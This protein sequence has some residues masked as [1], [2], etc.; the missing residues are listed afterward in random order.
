MPGIKLIIFSLFYWLYIGTGKTAIV[1]EVS[2]KLQ[3]TLLKV[4]TSQLF[5][6]YEK[7]TV[8]QEV[9]L[10]YIFSRYTGDSEKMIDK[11]FEAA[12]ELSLNRPV[13]V[14]IDEIDSIC[15]SRRDDGKDGVTSR[16]VTNLLMTKI[17]G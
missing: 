14:F 10:I 11:Y 4:E 7:Q 17:S 13:I 1:E 9:L 2:E 15:L 5:S 6:K 8:K 16:Q 3:M 12:E